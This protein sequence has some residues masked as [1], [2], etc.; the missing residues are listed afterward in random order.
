MVDVVAEVYGQRVVLIPLFRDS[1]KSFGYNSEP[2]IARPLQMIETLTDCLP[3]RVEINKSVLCEASKR[4][5]VRQRVRYRGPRMWPGL[6]TARHVLEV[7]G[8]RAHLGR[9]C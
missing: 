8:P 1:L 4:E 2:E 5:F 3:Q 7:G 9:R 6:R